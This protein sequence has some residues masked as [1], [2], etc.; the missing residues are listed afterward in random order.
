MYFKN[1]ASPI[2]INS[3]KLLMKNLHH[4]KTGDILTLESKVINLRNV[5]VI[6][7]TEKTPKHLI[8]LILSANNGLDIKELELSPDSF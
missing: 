6:A 3:W 4:L 1:K 2:F 7:I 5:F 8:Q